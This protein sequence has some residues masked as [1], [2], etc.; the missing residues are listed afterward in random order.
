[1]TVANLEILTVQ[2]TE[3]DPEAPAYSLFNFI[4]NRLELLPVPANG[5]SELRILLFDLQLRDHLFRED[6]VGEWTDFR[7]NT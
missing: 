5:V 2:E 4:F 1:M 7:N 3:I 6:A